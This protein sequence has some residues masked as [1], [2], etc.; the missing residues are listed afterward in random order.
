MTAPLQIERLTRRFGRRAVLADLTLAVESGE[1]VVLAGESGSGKTSMLRVVGGLDRADAGSVTI[2][3][4]M[5]EDADRIFLP[6]EQRGLGMVFQDFALWPHLSVLENVALAVPRGRERRRRAQDLLERLGVGA[7]APRLPATLSGGQQQRVGIARA[8]AAEP[9]LLLLDEPLSSLDL[10]TRET[11]R[12]ELRSLIADSGLTALCVSHD[13]ADCV[14]LGDR[15]AVLETGQ[16]SQCGT[17]ESL[18]A[19]PRSAYAARLAGL[20]G[21]VTL[22]AEPSGA[23]VV[24]RFGAAPV[25]VPGATLAGGTQ[26]VRVF[27]PTGAIRPADPQGGDGLHAA[28]QQVRFDAGTYRASYRIDGL[29]EPMTVIL[30]ERPPLGSARLVID[31]A[32]LRLVSLRPGAG[33]LA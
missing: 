15:I 18:F 3:G 11:L 24:L 8:L 5:V 26:R 23:D 1:C 19:A 13:P 9:R 10:E 27:W 32:L 33:R 7:C 17:P 2:A 22:E 25:R 31:G 30:A 21:G 20:L 29:A 12:A 14:H 4:R 28:C 6:P 16:I